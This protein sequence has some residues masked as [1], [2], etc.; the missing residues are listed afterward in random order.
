[1]DPIAL[2]REL[3]RIDKR[4]AGLTAERQELEAARLAVIGATI[5]P[6]AP[7]IGLTHQAAAHEK[8]ALFRSLF[9]GRTDVYPVR[10]ENQKAD[11][12]GYS[13]ACANEWVRGVCG[14][15][16]VKC[17]DCPQ[18]AFLAVTDSMLERHLR[19]DIIAGVYP[20]LSNHTCYFVA[21]DFDGEGW[22]A[23]SNAFLEACRTYQVPAARERSRS[24]A[25]AHV[26][27]F[28]QQ[29][30]EASRARQLATALLAAAMEVRPELALSS[31]DRLFPSQDWMPKGGFGN[32]IALPLQRQARDRGHSVFVDELLSPYPDQWAYLASIPKIGRLQL[33]DLM[34][35]LAPKQ[36]GVTGIRLPTND[37]DSNTPWAVTDETA[38]DTPISD[39][40][41]KR[42][43]VTL[44]DQIYIDR[45]ALP[46]SMVTRLLRLAAFQNPAFYQAQAMRFPTFDKPRVI[47]C[48]AL[49]PRHIVL[50]RGCLDDVRQVL[51][52]HSVQIDLSDDRQMGE[53]LTVSFIGTLRPEQRTA[54]D[55]LLRHDAGVLAATTAFG[56]TVLAISL[57]AAR[58]RNVL[59]L[60]HR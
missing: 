13:P 50:P 8:I 57:I 38:S 19:G 7:R 5:Q 58:G 56:K 33:E 3:E 51:D 54:A 55:A 4:L 31:F 1:M 16:R 30:L 49:N 25:G 44:A 11:R 12:A 32:L 59:I 29:P 24:G 40:L 47:S 46:A 28:F 39:P 15:P 53:P 23:D 45:T 48:A 22:A 6:A 52:D 42:L 10:W 2:Q 18:Q 43:S 9:R 17:G 27:I 60:V 21:A 35:S 26:W 14:K 41:P 34:K 20:L 37:E 36:H